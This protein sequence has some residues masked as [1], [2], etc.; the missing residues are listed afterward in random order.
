VS[1]LPARSEGQFN[2]LITHWEVST[3]DFS[4]SRDR[5]VEV[6][7]PVTAQNRRPATLEGHC[8]NGGVGQGR[9]RPAG[10]PGTSSSPSAMAPCGSS[11]SREDSTVGTRKVDQ[12]SS[13]PGS[14]ETTATMRAAVAGLASR[15]M[16]RWSAASSSTAAMTRRSPRVGS[17]L[18]ERRL[19]QVG[20]GFSEGKRGLPPESSRGGA[21]QAR[22]DRVWATDTRQRARRRRGGRS[23]DTIRRPSARASPRQTA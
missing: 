22:R 3:S 10:P 20:A 8:R 7:G 11:P 17:T 14:A 21:T 6:V 23:R 5:D 19:H 15:L 18:R 1:G 13:S 9:H 4:I 16:G 12:R 2:G